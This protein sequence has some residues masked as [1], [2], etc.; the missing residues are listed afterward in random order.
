MSV[1][2]CEHFP[3]TCYESNGKIEQ[4]E[5]KV[6]KGAWR[7]ALGSIAETFSENSRS[8]FCFLAFDSSR[9]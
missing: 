7:F 5:K 6:M 4:R 9:W 3:K 8:K 2:A 1:N